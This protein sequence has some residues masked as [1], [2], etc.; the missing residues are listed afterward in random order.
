MATMGLLSVFSVRK[1]TFSKYSERMA[2]RLVTTVA[3]YSNFFYP[4]VYVFVVDFPN[5]MPNFVVT[6]SRE[7]S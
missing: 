2:R 1:L 7:N 6:L 5:V 3:F 4:C